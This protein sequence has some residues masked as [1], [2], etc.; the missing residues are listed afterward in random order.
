MYDL[1]E[2]VSVGR[3]AKVSRV[4]M[5]SDT[6]TNYSKELHDLM[7]TPAV[8]RLAMQASAEAIDEFLPEGYISIGRQLE[9]EHT[10]STF[11]GVKVT[12]EA[13]VIE[14]QPLYI[15]F[16]IRATDEL[17]EI[18]FGRHRRS[19][20]NIESLLRRAKARKEQM[21]NSRA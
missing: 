4:I 11:L 17:G 13:T 15:V 9:F 3:S 2:L 16:D 6:A 21:L 8:I 14:V 19:I 10:A 1:R 5:E 20:A 18:G 7:A 12:V